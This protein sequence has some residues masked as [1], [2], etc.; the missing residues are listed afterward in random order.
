MTP[1]RLSTSHLLDWCFLVGTKN[2]ILSLFNICNKT[3]AGYRHEC[4]TKHSTKKKVTKKPPVK[5]ACNDYAV[6]KGN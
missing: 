1:V 4:A 6:S 3:V 2:N 5:A